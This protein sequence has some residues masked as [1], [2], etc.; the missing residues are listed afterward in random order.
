MMQV[1]R[2]TRRRSV[3]LAALVGSLPAVVAAWFTWAVNKGVL[4][5]FGTVGFGVSVLIIIG[6]W[7]GVAVG[8]MRAVLLAGRMLPG[9]LAGVFSVFALLTVV[10][11]GQAPDER[12]ATVVSPGA[13]LGA[14]FIIA[15]PSTI[16]LLFA[17]KQ[18][19]RC[20]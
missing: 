2:P 20:R 15:V 17:E 13:W 8:V 6:W 3:A 19:T 5:E 14:A 12:V 18:L 9:V 1:D 10:L 16:G 4:S 7:M 11:L